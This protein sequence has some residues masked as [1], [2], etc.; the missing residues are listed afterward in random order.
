MMERVDLIQDAIVRG[1]WPAVFREASAWAED[2]ARTSRKDHRPHFAM[3][4]VHIYRGEDRESWKTHASSL[5]DADDIETVR[6]WTEAM[7]KAHPDHANVY[8][9]TGLFLSQSGRSEQSVDRYK[10]AIKLEPLAAYPHFFLGQTHERAG[11]NELAIKEYREAVKLDPS[12]LAATTNLGVAYQEQR[13]LETALPQY[14][15]VIRRSANDP[16]AH[17]TIGCASA[18]QGK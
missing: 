5:Q 7:L 15:E 18:E 13:R 16:L 2:I 8:L 11:R 17:T 1:D 4:V 3:S 10:E 14:R 9:V 6:A 12:F